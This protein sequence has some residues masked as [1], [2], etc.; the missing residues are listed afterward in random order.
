M[1][2]GFTYDE[3]MNRIPWCVLMMM[4]N[5]QGKLKDKN[6]P[7]EEEQIIDSEEEELEFLGL[8]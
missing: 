7:P 4:V 6:E 1:Q 5:D 2:S 8:A 3:I